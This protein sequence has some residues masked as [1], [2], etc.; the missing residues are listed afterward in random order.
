ML[1]VVV[2][3]LRAIGFADVFDQFLNV[4]GGFDNVDDIL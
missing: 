1:V 2:V 3:R 4:L